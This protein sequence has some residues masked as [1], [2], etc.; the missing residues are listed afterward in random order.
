MPLSHSTVCTTHLPTEWTPVSIYALKATLLSLL[1]IMSDALRSYLLQ[2]RQ[3]LAI[4]LCDRLY[5]YEI[6]LGPDGQPTGQQGPRQAKPSK[7][8]MAFQKRR[9]VIRLYELHAYCFQLHGQVA[10]WQLG[11]ETMKKMKVA[12]TLPMNCQGDVVGL[13]GSLRDA[14]CSPPL[15][16]ESTTSTSSKLVASCLALQ[17]QRLTCPTPLMNHKKSA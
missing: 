17:A 8:W 5:P 12:I 2:T 15:T 6:S 1:I 14:S 11:Y 10:G 3:E 7:W 4:R 16:R 9:C 13:A